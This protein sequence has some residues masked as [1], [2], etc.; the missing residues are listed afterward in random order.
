VSPTDIGQVRAGQGTSTT[1]LGIAPRNYTVFRD[2]NANGNVSPTDFAVVR[3]AQGTTLEGVAQPPPA[4]LGGA[5]GGRGSDD[6]DS[7]RALLA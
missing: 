4:I 1:N 5:S 3:G 6:E 7:L 2:V